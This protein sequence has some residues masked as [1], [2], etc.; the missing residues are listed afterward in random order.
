MTNAP[1]DKTT[2]SDGSV[3]VT[4]TQQSSSEQGASSGDYSGDDWGGDEE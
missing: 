3:D 4:N 2:Q 1:Q